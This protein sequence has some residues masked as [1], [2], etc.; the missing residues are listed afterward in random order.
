MGKIF[1]RLEEWIVVIVLSIMSTIAFV[2]ILSRGFANYSFSFTEEITVNLF[3]LLTFVGTAI[4]VRKYAHLG[5]TLIYDKGSLLLKNII[6]ILVGLM[7]MLLFFILLYFGLKMVQYQMDMGQKTP[8]LGWPQWWFSMS[9]PIGALFCL[10][11][12]IQ[13]TIVEFRQQNEKGEQ[14]L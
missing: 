3:V 9:M 7:M 14:P 2:N 8:S 12:S 13:V 6:T 1:N 10:I 5:F 4:G 11:R